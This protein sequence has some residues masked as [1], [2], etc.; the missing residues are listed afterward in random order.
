M[1]KIILFASLCALAL[2]GCTKEAVEDKQGT[3]GQGKSITILGTLDDSNAT[4]V[5]IGDYTAGDTTVPLLWTSD[6]QIVVGAYDSEGNLLQGRRDGRHLRAVPEHAA[7]SDE[8]RNRLQGH[9]RPRK[10]QPVIQYPLQHGCGHHV[11]DR[12]RYGDQHRQYRRAAVLERVYH[13]DAGA[14]G[15]GQNRLRCRKGCRPDALLSGR[16]RYGQRICTSG[17]RHE[18]FGTAGIAGRLVHQRHEG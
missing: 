5:E 11:P 7:D 15:L 18:R 8:F 4:R 6:D 12:P 2:A 1:K 14:Q 17:T 9:R 16:R 13:P 10:A 3:E